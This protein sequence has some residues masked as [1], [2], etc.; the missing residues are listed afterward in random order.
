ML[1]LQAN[2]IT[3]NICANQ[4][5]RQLEGVIVKQADEHGES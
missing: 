1:P 2:A 5:A 3:A 4:T